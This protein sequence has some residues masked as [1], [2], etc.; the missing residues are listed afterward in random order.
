MSQHPRLGTA[1]KNDCASCYVGELESGLGPAGG[2]RV[3]HVPLI[4]EHLPSQCQGRADR[5]ITV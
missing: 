2:R 3:L 1:H 4:R 5:P